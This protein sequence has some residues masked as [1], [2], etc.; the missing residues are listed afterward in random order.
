MEYLEKIVLVNYI[1]GF[2]ICV[3]FNVMKS[4]L[5]IISLTLNIMMKTAIA[6][7]CVTNG[8]KFNNTRTLI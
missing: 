5:G 4:N 1:S 7:Y 2:V 8:L 6:G 3:L